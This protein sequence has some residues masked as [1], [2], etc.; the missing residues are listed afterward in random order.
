[1]SHYLPG[2]PL[3]RVGSSLV[4][5]ASFRPRGWTRRTEVSVQEMGHAV[6][7]C[8]QSEVGTVV[9]PDSNELWENQNVVKS[10]LILDSKILERT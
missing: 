2:S 3:D 7:S 4:T 10:L 5:N 9:V 8:E 1:M 6:T